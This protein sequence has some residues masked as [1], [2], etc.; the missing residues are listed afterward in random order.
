MYFKNYTNIDNFCVMDRPISVSTNQSLLTSTVPDQEPKKNISSVK[1][2]SKAIS[3]STLTLSKNEEKK[4]PS[5]KT[6]KS[7]RDTLDSDSEE[8]PPIT[9]KKTLKRKISSKTDDDS[10]TLKEKKKKPNKTAENQVFLYLYIFILII[11]YFY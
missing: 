6:S 1:Q 4:L 10:S 9:E 7:K 3:D 11:H 2:S 5:Q 8:E